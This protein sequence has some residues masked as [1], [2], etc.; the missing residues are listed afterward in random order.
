MVLHSALFSTVKEKTSG[1]RDTSG[2]A[3][4]GNP[5]DAEGGV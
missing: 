4:P 1:Q 5:G 2:W 3:N